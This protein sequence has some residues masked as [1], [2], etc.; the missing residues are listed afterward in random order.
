MRHIIKINL[1]LLFFTSLN[2]TIDIQ[3]ARKVAENIIVERSN[4]NSIK[5][6]IVD[7]ANGV[8]NFYIFNLEPSGFV[9]VSANENI[10]PIL[11]YSFN[12]NLDLNNLPVQLNKVLNSYRENIFPMSYLS[13][14]CKAL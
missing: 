11:G 4:N 10:I 12:K 5:N 3:M 6:F 14:L 8:D 9:I 2:A 1:I 13:Y 7:T